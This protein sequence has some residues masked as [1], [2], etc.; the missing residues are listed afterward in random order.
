MEGNK[1]S[2]VSRNNK[3]RFRLLRTSDSDMTRNS[4]KYVRVKFS[5]ELRNKTK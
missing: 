1:L 2:R 5:K 3:H 4:I